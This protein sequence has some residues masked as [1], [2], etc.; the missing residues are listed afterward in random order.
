MSNTEQPAAGAITEPRPTGPID[1]WFD[2]TC[3]FTWQTS[4]WLRE[5]THSRRLTVQWRLMSL[6]VLNEGRD[7]PAELQDDM[8]Q[9]T[10]VLRVL[11]AAQKQGGSE[12]VG[13]L[14]AA[15][16]V[17]RHEQGCTYDEGTVRSAVR[18][19]GLPADIADAADDADWDEA[20][21]ASHKQGQSRVG[22]EA[23]SPVLSLDGERGFFGPV[24]VPAPTGQDAERLFEGMW[25]LSRVPAFS[26]TKTERAQL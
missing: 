15:L 26:E 6:P 7:V 16:G 19:A 18:E 12:A 24:V 23:G 5:V 22:T 10:R 25:L 20:V 9:S 14:Y 4:R 1:F 21:R 11:A 17:R 8:H 2:P 13:R 3:P